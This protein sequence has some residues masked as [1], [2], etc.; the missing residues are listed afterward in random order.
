M[1]N[2]KARIWFPPVHSSLTTLPS[3][4]DLCILLEQLK[5]VP[6]LLLDIGK[7]RSRLAASGAGAALVVPSVQRMT[8]PQPAAAAQQ[9]TEGAAAAAAEQPAPPPPLPAA[10]G[11]G[12]GGEAPPPL[13]DAD[14]A[15]PAGGAAAGVAAAAEVEAAPALPDEDEDGAAP[16]LPPADGEYDEE[17]PLVV[18]EREREAA[19]RAKLAADEIPPYDA[20]ALKVCGGP[21]GGRMRQGRILVTSY[22]QRTPV[23]LLAFSQEF[24]SDLKDVEREAEVTRILGA[25]KLNP[26]EQM[27]LRND[28]T[29]EEIK[30]Q[31]RKV[32]A[33]GTECRVLDNW[34][35][36]GLG[37]CCA[38]GGC[39]VGRCAWLAGWVGVG[40]CCRCTGCACG[41]GAAAEEPPFDHA[42]GPPHPPTSPPPHRPR[43]CRSWCTRTS[44][45]TRGPRTRLR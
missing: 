23:P 7:P 12:S 31:Y 9:P 21:E 29:P 15:P 3:G 33:L 43:R 20:D 39:A 2:L 40:R 45:G 10:D 36:G 24:Y 26:Y 8:D 28:A 42:M 27:G 1:N 13:P 41:A 34:V 6:E 19:E 25:F 14:I 35:V 4:L 38:V 18:A 16:P 22:S 17:D 30:K 5:I 44:V 32:G 11:G 37:Y